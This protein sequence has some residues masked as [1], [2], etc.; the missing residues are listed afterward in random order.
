MEAYGP[1]EEEDESGPMDFEQ[2]ARLGERLEEP[3]EQPSTSPPKKRAARFLSMRISQM[4][5][6]PPRNLVRSTHP[7]LM[8]PRTRCIS[9]RPGEHLFVVAFLSLSF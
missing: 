3:D 8:G 7:L 5:S 9:I 4:H 1:E 2:G 6:V